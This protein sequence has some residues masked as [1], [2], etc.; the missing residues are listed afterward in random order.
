MNCHKYLDKPYFDRIV[1]NLLKALTLFIAVGGVLT[2]QCQS[3]RTQPEI[4]KPS[5]ERFERTLGIVQPD[6]RAVGSSDKAD[7]V[8]LYDSEGELWF[9]YSLDEKHPKYLMASKTHKL[10]PLFPPAYSYFKLVGVSEHW[11]AVQTDYESSDRKYMR[12]DDPFLRQS[13]IEDLIVIAREIRVNLKTNP[14]Y[15]KPGGNEVP[16]GLEVA[17]WRPVGVI[18][19]DWLQIEPIKPTNQPKVYGW[20]R[21]RRGNDLLI[22]FSL[23]S[24][25]V[26][27]ESNPNE[28]TPN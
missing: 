11:F 23:L 28:T 21:W 8:R 15:T 27:S 9:E 26:F 24:G 10:R 17:G 12:K 5:E 1:S 14:L 18:S 20:V 2:A 13:K 7:T 19:G 3:V 25:K 16:S 4:G 22:S 6:T